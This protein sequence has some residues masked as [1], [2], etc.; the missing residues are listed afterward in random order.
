MLRTHRTQ[1]PASDPVVTA[2]ADDDEGSD[3]PGTTDA[4]DDE[5]AEATR[6]DASGP[7]TTAA[8]VGI[9]NGTDVDGVV[10]FAFAA[11]AAGAIAEGR[12]VAKDAR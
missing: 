6:E 9:G 2:A 4:E 11:A 7:E 8:V 10:D 12:A 5:D 3:N 1:G